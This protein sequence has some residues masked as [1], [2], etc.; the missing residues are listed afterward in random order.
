[1]TENTYIK[2]MKQEKSEKLA[3]KGVNPK[4]Q[5]VSSGNTRGGK[6]TISKKV[7]IDSTKNVTVLVGVVV[8][9]VGF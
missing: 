7:S 1:M 3:C 4:E 8:V 9:V 6:S 2:E 5:K